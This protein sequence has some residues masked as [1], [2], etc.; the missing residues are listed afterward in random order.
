MN[1]NNDWGIVAVDAHGRPLPVQ[2]P[3]PPGM[4][5]KLAAMQAQYEKQVE[6]AIERF[7]AEGVGSI[8]LT[9]MQEIVLRSLNPSDGEF[10]YL[11]TYHRVIAAKLCD[12]AKL[13]E[14]RGEVR[15]NRDGASYSYRRSLLG[16]MY[17]ENRDRSRLG[18]NDA[19]G[20]PAIVVPSNEFEILG[21]APAVYHRENDTHLQEMRKQTKEQKK[22]TGILEQILENTTSIHGT[23]EDIFRPESMKPEPDT[24]NGVQAELEPLATIVEGIERECREKDCPLPSSGDMGNTLWGT[25]AE[26]QEYLSANPESIQSYFAKATDVFTANDGTRYVRITSNKKQY[27][28]IAA[29]RNQNKGYRWFIWKASLDFILEKPDN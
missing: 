10:E 5:E 17:I 2:P 16:D 12:D 9:E 19:G 26:Q 28:L 29:K 20:F 11:P 21:P 22:H 14:G 18:Q 8:N 3:L 6:A 24:E 23:L 15:S 4:G 27:G 7:E 1:E 25:I 13:V